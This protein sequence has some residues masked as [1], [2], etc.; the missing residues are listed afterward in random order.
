MLPPKLISLCIAQIRAA[1]VVAQEVSRRDL[2]GCVRRDRA[3]VFRHADILVALL[4]L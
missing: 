3:G 2:A 1:D 4:L